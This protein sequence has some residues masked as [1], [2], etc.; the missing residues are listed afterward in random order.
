MF[1]KLLS[2]LA[3]SIAS[4]LPAQQPQANDLPPTQP[5]FKTNAEFVNGVAPG[6]WPTA[7]ATGLTLNIS[8][9]TAN[10]SGIKNY[11][12]GTLALTN[13]TTNYVYLDTTNNCI[14]TASTITFTASQIP[15]AIVVTSGGNIT[16]IVD[17]RT[18]FF[19]SGSSLTSPL[20]TKGDIWGFSTVN[21]R[22]PV[23]ADGTFLTA[24]STQPLGVKWASLGGPVL[25]LPSTT[26]IVWTGSSRIL[27]DTAVL[28][29]PITVTGGSI[30]GGIATVTTSAGNP[31]I[32]DW[33]NLVNLGAPFNTGPATVG[34]ATGYQIF[35]VLG[36]GHTSTQFQVAY[37][38]ATGS[39]PAGT[40]YQVNGTLP[41]WTMNNEPW[42]TGTN[43]NLIVDVA[44]GATLNSLALNYAANLHPFSP[45]VTGNPALLI[46][47]G[48]GENDIQGCDT[49]QNLESYYKSLWIQAHKDGYTVLQGDIWPTGWNFISCPNGNVNFSL[50]NQWL[51]TQTKPV[52]GMNT[53]TSTT[54]SPVISTNTFTVASATNIVIGQMVVDLTTPGNLGPGT[55]VTNIVGTTVTISKVAVAS[56]TNDSL[57]F[58]NAEY[59]DKFAEVGNALTTDVAPLQ[60][61]N[62]GPGPNGVQLVADEYDLALSTQHGVTTS[63]WDR[64]TGYYSNNGELMQY[65]PLSAIQAAGWI[66]VFSGNNDCLVCADT[67][68]D[69]VDFNGQRMRISPNQVN[70]PIIQL[71]DP[72]TGGAN[73]AVF[74][75]QGGASFP[76][77]FGVYAYYAIA[78]GDLG[79]IGYFGTTATGAPLGRETYRFGLQS[80]SG[81]FQELWFDSTGLTYFPSLALPASGLFYCTHIDVLGTFTSTGS[82]CAT[83]AEVVTFSATPTFSTVPNVSRIVLTANITSFTLGAGKDGQIKTLCFKQGSGPFTVAAPA[84]VHGFFTIGTT[85]ALWNC[86]P[87]VYDNTDSI[88]QASSTGVINQ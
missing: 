76:N 30:S 10:C 54:G 34:Q 11:S 84:N 9:G 37:T 17:V 71:T 12:G 65:L 18:P 29:L 40:A 55:S 8:A 77:S 32:G 41:M 80:G 58:S 3:L 38:F 51:R 1:K 42:F 20:T 35:K 2:I 33:V 85:N 28:S 44:G 72:Q 49:Y 57:Y 87:F 73:Y 75:A 82:D 48:G 46:I 24:D 14:P 13:S 74:G 61:T 4:L 15:V 5:I 52:V 62:G 7:A 47:N 56:G 59:W 83:G 26:N 63:I 70:G 86:Q 25:Y 27:D 43:G 16:S 60:A 39:V 45:A 64:Y 36:T 53:T 79:S 22:I 81:T 21:A 19:S 69:E 67:T 78:N 68:Q 50:T 6:Y 31:N 66:N 23:G 88:W